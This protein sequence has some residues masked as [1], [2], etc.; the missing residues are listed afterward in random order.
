M[1][2]IA[3]INKQKMLRRLKKN[4]IVYGSNLVINGNILLS[5]T[6][7]L[8]IGDNVKINSG[9]INPVG[10]EVCTSFSTVEGAW[11]KIGNNVGMSNVTMYARAGINIEDDVIIGGGCRIYDTDFH[12]IQF[13][14]RI[15]NFKQEIVSR[16]INVK[17]GAFIG[18]HTIILKGVEIGEGSVIGAG[19]VVT[20]SI[21]A[22]EIWAGNPARF[23]RKIQ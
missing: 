11:I 12:P 3:L 21:P 14:H 15:K 10:N 5:D 23:I 4:N 8:L 22:G 13:E 2:I 19:S 9:F 16:T 18:A 17:K 7:N 1:R 6:I 20:K